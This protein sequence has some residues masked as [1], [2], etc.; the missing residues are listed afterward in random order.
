MQHQMRKV[1]QAKHLEDEVIVAVPE[2]ADS[3]EE[4]GWE[5]SEGGQHVYEQKASRHT[6]MGSA[7]CRVH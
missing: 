6:Y 1:R 2:E 4:E 5:R 3:R 7:C